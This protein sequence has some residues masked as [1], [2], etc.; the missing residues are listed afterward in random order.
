MERLGQVLA[1]QRGHL[2]PWLAVF[3]ASGIGTYFALRFEP[4]PWHYGAIGAVGMVLALASIPRS[5]FC[6]PLGLALIFMLAGFAVAGLRAHSLAEPVLEWRYY[7][8]VEGRVVAM[9][10][11]ASDAVRL[12]LDQVV[13]FNMPPEKTP[14]RVRI[15]L[16]GDAA[17]FGAPQSG[18]RVMTTSHLGPPGGPVEPRGFDFQRHAWFLRL[19][20]VGYTRVP[21]LELEAPEG[22][23]VFRMRMAVSE[24]VRTI[25]PGDTGGFAA[26]VT[27][28][29]RSGI[30]QDALEALRAANTAHL[31]AISG[32]HM[33]LLS[34][35]VFGLLRVGLALSPFIALRWPTRRIAAAGALVAAAI[36]LALSGGNVA[37]ER[38][39]IMVAVALCAVMIDRRALTLRA[40]A[41]A[42]LIVL[43]LRP[44]ALLGPGFQMS[45]AATTALVAVFEHVRQNKLGWGVPGLN[46]FLALM[47]TSAVAG[48]ATGPIG[49]AHFNAVSHYGLMANMMSVPIMGILVIPAAVLAGVLA[50]F[51]LENWGFWL[52]GWGLDWILLVSHFWSGLEG[53]RSFVPG[54]Q[55]FVLPMIALGAM[56][57]ILWQNRW[58]WVGVVPIVLAFTAWTQVQ[59]PTMLIAEGGTLV[60][61]LTSEGRALSKPKGAGFIA[62]NWLEND[63]ERV[64]QAEA[65]LR[66]PKAGMRVA[67][68]EVVHLA[69][70]RQLNAFTG[71]TDAQIVV[72]SAAVEA[73]GCRLFDAK[74]LSATGAVALW[75][76][77]GG[78][79]IETVRSVTGQ[80]LWS[81]WP[82][83]KDQ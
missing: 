37:T 30:S 55:G 11:S 83:A 39:F 66:W 20:A 4:G 68:L 14:E 76:N 75:Q 63:G 22:Q 16:H 3:Y 45:F 53:A 40:V 64:E 70:K 1:K 47:L 74:T 81:R 60:G 78:M 33:G 19:G 36:Y 79:R 59:R 8:A 29:D 5:E 6:R 69:G 25:L 61:V 80:R 7:G 21:V 77:P 43:T 27:T 34:T 56:F 12:T 38:A 71:C 32:L 52:M 82:D 28:G 50:P 26:A 48:L 42:A 2:F 58:R 67:G 17:E 18:S 54:P 31:L 46:G 57:L 51:G 62:S 24:Q 15:S 10:R 73:E 41:I 13:L 72:A 44:E 65:A 35:F 23:R 49:A 9:D